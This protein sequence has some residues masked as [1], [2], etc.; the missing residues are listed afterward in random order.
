MLKELVQYLET[1]PAPHFE[2]YG[3][4]RYSDKELFTV[5]VAKPEVIGAS[6]LRAVAD[7]INNAVDDNTAFPLGRIIVHVVGPNV[8]EVLSECQPDGSR[9]QR[10]ISKAVVP[11]IPFGHFLDCEMFNI[12]L[13]SSFGDNEGRAKVLKIVGNIYDDS[14]VTTSDDGMTQNVTL[15]AGIQRLSS[16]EVI[17][18][19]KLAPYRTF[20]EV[21]QPESPFV[22]RL[23]SGH[24]GGAPSAALFEADGT[25]WRL[26]AIANIRAYFEDILPKDKQKSGDIIILA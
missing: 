24:G 9:Y 18:P 19:V 26:E 15:R 3:G 13:Q 22:F 25:A 23:Q 16:G 1:R 5:P 7:Y 10:I 17:N 2:D 11:D 8:V 21:A 4:Q 14:T 12:T 6:T 20:P